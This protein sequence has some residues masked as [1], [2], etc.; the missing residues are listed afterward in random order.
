VATVRYK[1]SGVT[2]TREVFISHPAKVLVLRITADKPGAVSIVAGLTSKLH[3]RT[4]TRGNELVLDGKAP[5]F[6]ANRDTEPQQVVYDTTPGGEGMTFQ[7]QVRAVAEGGQMT[8]DEK[9]LMVTGANSVTLYLTEATSF[10]GFDKSP[11]KEGRDPAQEAIVNMTRALQRGFAALRAEHIA[12]HQKLF[13]RVRLDLGNGAKAAT[14]P[15]D[16]RLRN[17]VKDPT[18]NGLVTLYYQFGRYLMIAAS[19]PGSRP[20]NLQGIWNDHVQPPW[21]SNYTTNI[22]TEMNYWPAENTNLSECH[23]PLFDFMKELAVNGAVT[24]KTN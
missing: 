21:G 20:T 8:A 19:R 13:R 4:R 16:E 9:G 15:T 23:Q 6:V 7:V 14:L 2:Y 17:F 1:A 12:D 22:N 11:A 10:N 18:D 5:K 24:A 3:Y